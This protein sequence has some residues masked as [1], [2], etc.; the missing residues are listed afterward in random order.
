MN[1][2]PA[3]LSAEIGLLITAPRFQ[4]TGLM[5]AAAA[6]LMQFCL[7]VPA[8]GGLGLRRLQW[9]T[10]SHNTASAALARR[11]G[12][13]LEG[14]IRWQR[15]LPPGKVGSGRGVRLGDPIPEKEGRDSLMLAVCWDD[16]EGGVAEKTCVPGWKMHAP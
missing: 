6:L 1:A 10:H 15:I 5:A 14:V 7:A 11:M 2:D 4:R 12:F 16:W 9:Q 3:S 13:V 8:E